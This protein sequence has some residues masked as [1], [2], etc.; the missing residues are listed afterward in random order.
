MSDQGP[1]TQ[2]LNL[3]IS[4]MRYLN[5]FYAL[6]YFYLSLPNTV[7]LL[8]IRKVKRSGQKN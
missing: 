1:L 2:E 7:G 3:H 8:K 4:L 6:Q 5:G